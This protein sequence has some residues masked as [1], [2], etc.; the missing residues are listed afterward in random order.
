MQS[1]RKRKQIYLH[2]YYIFSKIE[3]SNHK[4]FLIGSYKKRKEIDWRDKNWNQAE[5]PCFTALTSKL[6]TWMIITFNIKMF[7][8]FNI[9]I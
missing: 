4:S 9:K 7:I 5:L 1:L 6:C 8:T 2:S 3:K